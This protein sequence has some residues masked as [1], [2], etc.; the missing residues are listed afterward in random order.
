MSGTSDASTTDVDYSPSDATTAPPLSALFLIKFDQKVGYS[1]AWK[2]STADVVLDGTVEFKSL[3]SGL[4]TVKEDLVY[5]VHEGYA[6]LS[7][8][9]NGPASAAERN[10]HLVAVGILVPLSYGRLGRS[11]LHAQALQ[12]LAAV[13][14]GDVSKTEPLETYWENHG[15]NG[16]QDNPNLNSS[17]ISSGSNPSP[18]KTHNRSRALSSL[19]AVIPSEQSLPPWHP[20]LSIVK[21]IDTFG[22]LVF[23]LQ[24]AALLRKRILFMTS[25]PVRPACEFVYDLSILSSIPG[26]VS[27]LLPPGSE[28]L[29]RLRSLFTLGIHD[30]PL[31]EKMSV[32]HGAPGA[33]QSAEDD[34][35]YGW[36]ACTTDEIL[37][38]KQ[39]LY[40]IIVEIPATT[41]NAT[42]TKRWPTIKT[43]DGA[44]IKASQRDLRR[45]KLLYH[46]L[47]KIRHRVQSDHDG[48][49]D[50]NDQTFLIP[51]DPENESE[52]ESD[53]GY[54][55]KLIE[56]MT[57][58]QLAYSGFMWWASAGE[59]DSYLTEEADGDREILGDISDFVPGGMHI[60]SNG[61]DPMTASGLAQTGLHTAIIAY[62][63]RLTSVMVTTLADLIECS[64]DE[65]P[66]GDENT[67]LQVTSEDIARMGLEAWSESDKAFAKDFL[68]TYFGRDAEVH[69]ASLECCGLRVC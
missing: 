9:V 51:H 54:D 25:A 27:E 6:G 67:V 14:V 36:V 17:N 28:S 41:D 42:E 49:E 21:Y 4:H 69:G 48:D 52:D 44:E 26:S 34:A 38:I 10:A 2:R 66:T 32:P 50:T 20:A 56:P 62:F 23:P 39:K 60:E 31:L 61:A 30:I 43:C 40:D 65:D 7:A 33:T 68:M 22:P 46:E 18:W 29:H 24:R 63:H 19:I 13:L 58:A 45:F 53:E 35:T 59:K 11:W 12:N 55:D 15:A 37:T 64:D 5:F 3:P 57:W 8:F 1:I 16:D 47:W